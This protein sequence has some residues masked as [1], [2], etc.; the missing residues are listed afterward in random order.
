MDDEDADTHNMEGVV[1][2]TLTIFGVRPISIGKVSL[3]LGDCLAFFTGANSIPAIGFNDICTLNFNP[4]NIYPTASTC[5]LVL[6][7]PTIHH[8]SYSMFREKMLFGLANHGG[9]GLC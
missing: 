9:F 6:T 7:L 2:T 8:G 3:D 5:A 1:T 4:T